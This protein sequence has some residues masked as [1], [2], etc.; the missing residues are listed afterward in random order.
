MIQGWGES[1]LPPLALVR[2][3]VVE[4]EMEMKHKELGR[5]EQTPFSQCPR[6]GRGEGTQ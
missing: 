4:E 2:I 6:T 5:G 1:F 3:D